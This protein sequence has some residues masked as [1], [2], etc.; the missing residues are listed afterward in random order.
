MKT[1]WQK[2]EE[3]EVVNLARVLNE[4]RFDRRQVWMYQE[5]RC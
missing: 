3:S 5:K 1:E 4:H 2:V